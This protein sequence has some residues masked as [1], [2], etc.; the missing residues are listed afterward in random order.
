MTAFVYVGPYI[1]VTPG[2]FDSFYQK[3][4]CSGDQEHVVGDRGHFCSTCGKPVETKD[5]KEAV[6]LTIV[7]VQSDDVQ[8][9]IITAE[10]QDWILD[11]FSSVPGEY[12]GEDRCEFIMFNEV[13]TYFDVSHSKPINLDATNIEITEELRKQYERLCE[14]M[15]FKK[16]EL[17]SG[18]VGGYD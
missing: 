12:V 2:T 17:L 10:D 16:S 1:K 9:D 7:A 5:V 11:N 4:V 13:T 8:L 18:I 6:S 15:K 3:A 14:I